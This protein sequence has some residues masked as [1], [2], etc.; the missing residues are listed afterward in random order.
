MVKLELSVNL[1]N[2]M[3]IKVISDEHQDKMDAYR[4]ILDVVEDWHSLSKFA[5][6]IANHLREILGVK[7]NPGG[8]TKVQ[9]VD[10]P[11]YDEAMKERIK[12]EMVSQIDEIQFGGPGEGKKHK[13][14][15]TLCD[16]CKGH[17]TWDFR[18]SI[19][20]P[21]HVNSHGYLIGDGSCSKFDKNN[22]E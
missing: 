22:K 6:M 1:D 8:S 17:I 11:A 3:H 10:T 14:S 21:M 2:L 15:K 20:Y 13:I 9:L 19:S 16:R 7:E 4:E 5:I 18:P 12:G